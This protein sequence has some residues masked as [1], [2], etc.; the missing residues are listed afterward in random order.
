MF[1]DLNGINGGDFYISYV[2]LIDKLL[3]CWVYDVC[4]EV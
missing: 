3:K 4:Y 1:K 2:Y